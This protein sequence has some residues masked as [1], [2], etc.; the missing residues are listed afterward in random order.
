MN[1]YSI[2]AY[3]EESGKGL[4]RHIFVRTN[5]KNEVLVCLVTNYE[6]IPHFDKLKEML[7][8]NC[9]H[10]YAIVQNI[11]S[12]KVNTIRGSKY[13]TIYGPGTIIDE[14]CG[15]KFELDTASFFQINRI[16]AENLYTAALDM[17]DI[18]KKDLVLDLYCGTGTITLLL[19]KRA[20]HAIGVEIVEQAILNA[21]K[22]AK[23]N[24]VT[25]VD[26]ICSNSKN[27]SADLLKKGISPDVICV[28]PPRKGLDVSTIESCVKL[29]PKQLVYISCKPETLARDLRIF[30]DSGYDIENVIMVD[31]FPR[32]AHV[33]TAV[34]LKKCT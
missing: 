19:A 22:N 28:D 8:N 16:Q 33:E 12:K 29:Q 11:N 18:S 10:V 5:Y 17:A 9:E 32:T 31:M 21:K 20:Q 25:N 6:Y 3:I 14:L 13:K 34:L 2:S 23:R 27:A 15:L 7:V 26:F 30:K 4:L 24:D 1:E